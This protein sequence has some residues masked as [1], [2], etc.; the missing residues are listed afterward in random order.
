M[1]NPFDVDND[2]R[3][4]DSKFIGTRS[5]EWS[6]TPLSRP[7]E[8]KPK[9]SEEPVEDI[10]VAE[11]FEDV[12]EEARNQA[13]EAEGD[14]G[15]VEDTKEEI[16]EQEETENKEES[17]ANRATSARGEGV[18][19][20]GGRGGLNPQPGQVM[21]G[22]KWR[23]REL[24]SIVRVCVLIMKKKLI[25]FHGSVSD[26]SDY[27]IDYYYPKDFKMYSESPAVF[28]L[29]LM[30]VLNLALGENVGI[31]VVPS[32]NTVTKSSTTVTKSSIIEVLTCFL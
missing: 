12:G 4:E 13:E 23:G 25:V 28:D 10:G 11:V 8:M 27:T 18:S 5:R 26:S 32:L 21:Q 16:E 3:L 30:F 2:D 14:G 17:E 6:E 15:E 7:L 22:T 1:W 24:Q 31:E 20:F 9:A 19:V 29:K